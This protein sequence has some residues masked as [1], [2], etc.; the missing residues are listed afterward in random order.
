MSELRSWPRLELSGSSSFGESL[1]SMFMASLD[2]YKLLSALYSLLDLYFLYT[3]SLFPTGLKFECT[4]VYLTFDS[5]SFSQSSDFIV[6]YD[7]VC[8]GAITFLTPRVFFGFRPLFF[9]KYCGFTL[10]I[11]E[12][13]SW[14][15]DLAGVPNF[16]VSSDRLRGFGSFRK[17]STI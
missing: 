14:I 2:L 7:F 11:S 13:G 6:S 10:K 12:S 15:W 17:I 4:L 9:P 1:L 16:V 8:L 5:Y 3:Y